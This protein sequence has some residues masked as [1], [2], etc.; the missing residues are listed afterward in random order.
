MQSCPSHRF[1][2]HHTSHTQHAIIIMPWLLANIRLAQRPATVYKAVPDGCGPAQRALS[3]S[4]DAQATAGQVCN[5][6]P[7]PIQR[8]GNCH[9]IAAS[10]ERLVHK[11]ADGGDRISANRTRAR[12]SDHNTAYGR[13]AQRLFGRSQR[14]QTPSPR[15]AGAS[16]EA[17]YNKCME[18]GRSVVGN[19]PSSRSSIDHTWP[20]LHLMQVIGRRIDCIEAGGSADG[21][22]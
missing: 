20:S 19:D 8:V 16:I 5:F 21:V 12:S 11:D 13:W 6:T 15:T 14:T 22:A 9:V 4:R 18:T 7:T 10:D 1:H 2:I 3:D 17:V